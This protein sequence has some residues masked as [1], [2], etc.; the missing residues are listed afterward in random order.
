M[1][2]TVTQLIT[3]AF[4]AAGIVGREFET[5][6]GAEFNDG[7]IWLNDI[8]ME[9]TVDDGMIPY[10]TTYTGNFISG[11][12][13][14]YIENLISIDTLT[15][16]KDN[17]RYSMGYLKRNQ[18]FGSARTEGIDS[19]P[20]N[21]YFERGFGGGTLYVYF[22]PDTAYPFEIHGSFRLSEVTI[23][24]DLSL[25]LDRFYITYLRY[26]L[27]ERICAEYGEA[28]PEGVRSTL[29]KY[30]AWI[31]KKSKVLDLRLT[32]AST[33]QKNGRGLGWAWANLGKGWFPYG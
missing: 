28:V 7:L 13:S 31:N 8:L 30:Q 12:E 24:Q 29:G 11:Q 23:N 14:Y 26:A 9:K 19:L 22:L 10:E 33:L 4:Y 16:T 18:Y 25:T 3:G 5:V 6:S 21:W 32:K 27:A 17:V 15:F 20:F 2:Y 1:A